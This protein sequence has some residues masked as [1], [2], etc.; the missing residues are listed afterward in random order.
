MA[1]LNEQP[2]RTHLT[3]R[4]ARLG[5]GAFSVV[6]YSVAGEETV[7]QVPELGICFDAGRA[8]QFALTSDILC[9][10]HAHMD[11][12]AGIAYYASQRFFQGMKPPVVLLPHEIRDA[13]ADVLAAFGRLERQETPYQL[14]PMRPGELHKVR[15]DFGIRCHRTHHGGPSLAFS[16]VQIR[17]KLKDE[18]HGKS[19]DE[20][21]QLKKGGVEIQYTV[22][23]PLVT[24]TG[25][26]ADGDVFDE[27]D[28]YEAQVLLTECTFFDDGHRRK[29][30]AGRH[31]HVRQFAEILPTLECEHVVIL[32]VSRR[33]G[34]QRAKRTLRDLVGDDEMRRVHFLMDFKGSV[35][36]GDAAKA[37]E[38]GSLET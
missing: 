20:I 8:P 7:V 24:Y 11:H 37:S 13:V 34:V 31:L 12:V 29:A 35:R 16:A 18:F 17:R 19:G 22:E 15:A 1:A 23:V 27:P 14:V 26:T 5:F 32:H 38:G 10:S 6:G 21:V 9:L 33:T 4:F 25:D 2:E 3:Q 36:V 30:K 28:L